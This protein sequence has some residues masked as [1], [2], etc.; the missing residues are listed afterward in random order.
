WLNQQTVEYQQAF[1]QV[2]EKTISN[3]QNLVS[4]RQL[5]ATLS[6]GKSESKNLE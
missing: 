3:A 2:V 1:Q 4:H 6:S 5:L